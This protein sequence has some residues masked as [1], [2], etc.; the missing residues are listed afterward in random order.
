MVMVMASIHSMG[1]LADPEIVPAIV[2]ESS[3]RA[4]WQLTQSLPPLSEKRNRSPAFMCF[5]RVVDLVFFDPDNT[6]VVDARRDVSTTE[7]GD[8]FLF[9]EQ[10][11][12]VG[13]ARLE[14]NERA[15]V[16]G[17]PNVTM[18]PAH[19][20]VGGK[21]EAFIFSQ[22]ARAT[23]HQDGFAVQQNLG[24]FFGFVHGVGGVCE[25]EAVV[26]RVVSDREDQDVAGMNFSDREGL[27]GLSVVERDHEIE[28]SRFHL[29]PP[30]VIELVGLRRLACA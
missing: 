9:E 30:F 21:H 24:V 23:L 14:E 11:S 25:L 15:V 20:A 18:T 28:I 6:P 19:A 8:F 13:R 27:P 12:R 7:L 17:H 10:S 26:A 22:H 3:I 16:V 5:L 1:P 4:T 29:F 2:S